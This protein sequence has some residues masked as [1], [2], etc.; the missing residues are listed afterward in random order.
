MPRPELKQKKYEASYTMKIMHWNTL[1][2]FRADQ[3]Y[4][5]VV[6]KEYLKWSYRSFIILQNIKA[7][8]PDVFGLCDLE[9]GSKYKFFAQSLAKIGY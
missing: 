7:H 6:S 4:T 8:D 3:Q 5:G 2:S 9:S 1:S